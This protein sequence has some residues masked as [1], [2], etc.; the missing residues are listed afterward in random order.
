MA[1]RGPDKKK[2]QQR[3]DA[4]KPRNYVKDLQSVAD[5]GAEI[6]DQITRIELGIGNWSK[7]QKKQLAMMKTFNDQYAISEN[8]SQKKLDKAKEA[9][10]AMKVTLNQQSTMV[11]LEDELV[12]LKK[13]EGKVDTKNAQKPN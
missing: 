2:R 3:S 10:K 13:L 4:G 12:R 6:Q 8:Y 5:V 11:D 9:S 7:A 1:G